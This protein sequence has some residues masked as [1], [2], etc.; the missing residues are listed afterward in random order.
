MDSFWK[1]LAGL[2]VDALLARFGIK[3]DD[4]LTVDDLIGKLTTAVKAELS[5]ELD[6]LDDI[7]QQVITEV[8][9]QVNGVVQQIANIPAQVVGRLP[10]FATIIQQ[11]IQNLNPFK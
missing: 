2:A 1:K 10:D 4:K 11:A 3:P 6:K 7:P 5:E 9:Q 8:G